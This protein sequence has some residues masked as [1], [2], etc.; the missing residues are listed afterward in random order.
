MIVGTRTKE[1]LSMENSTAV[2]EFFA[3]SMAH[4]MKGHGKMVYL[5]GSACFE[6]RVLGLITQCI[7]MGM[8]LEW[9]SSGT[10][11]TQKHISP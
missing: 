7:K 3:G 4:S 5:T 6:L 2:K 9:V 11:I 1:T 8:L 10:Q